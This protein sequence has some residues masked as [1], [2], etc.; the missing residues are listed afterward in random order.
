MKQEVFGRNFSTKVSPGRSGVAVAF[1]LFAWALMVGG[2]GAAE[3]EGVISTHPE[4]IGKWAGEG[5]FLDVA[6]DK[7]LGK[8]ALEVEIGKDGTLTGKIGDAKLAKTSIAK[9]RYGFEIHAILDARVK[10]DKSEKRDHLIILLVTPVKDKD[11]ALVSDANF[12]LKSNFTF[13]LTMRVGGVMLK[14]QP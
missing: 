13:D 4:L 1:V 11:G 10:K 14:K 9:A 12:H 2:A 6:L 3:K 7:E 5:Q 8:V